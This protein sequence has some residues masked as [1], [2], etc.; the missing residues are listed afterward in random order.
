[1]GEHIQKRDGYSFCLTNVDCLR[2]ST[3]FNVVMDLESTIEDLMP[4]LA[5]CLPGCNYVHGSDVINLMDAG[6]IIG[7]HPKRITMTLVKGEKEAV[8]T[9]RARHPEGSAENQL[10]RLFLTD[11]HGLCGPGLS[12]RGGH[13]RM[14]PL[15]GGNRGAPGSPAADA[16]PWLQDPGTGSRL[17]PVG[18][19]AGREDRK[20]HRFTVRAHPAR[21]IPRSAAHED[22]TP[23]RRPS[24]HRS[25]QGRSRRRGDRAS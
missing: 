3:E 24:P 13:L 7:I 19:T 18:V 4:Y 23:P 2:T 21:R 25:R 12:Q 8:H 14:P 17:L 10:R 15:H 16:G 20:A 5:A 9:G 1:M 22:P 11:L 6:H